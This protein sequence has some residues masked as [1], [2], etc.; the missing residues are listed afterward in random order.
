MHQLKLS[1]DISGVSAAYQMAQKTDQLLAILEAPLAH[2]QPLG[3]LANELFWVEGRVPWLDEER[4]E[5]NL[6]D[7]GARRRL[8]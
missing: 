2:V 3:T 7:V 4:A 5:H 6:E 8:L 1:S